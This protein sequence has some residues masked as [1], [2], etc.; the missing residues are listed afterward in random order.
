MTVLLGSVR[1]HLLEYVI[2]DA[3]RSV[4]LGLGGIV[5]DH[6]VTQHGVSQSADVFRCDVVPAVKYSPRF[7]AEQ[8]ELHRPRSGAEGHQP[9][10]KWR[11]AIG[12]IACQ[13]LLADRSVGL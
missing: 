4:P 1:G 2:D 9:V 8:E 3:I 11:R 7:G 6:S 10:D 12:L 5:R 13:P